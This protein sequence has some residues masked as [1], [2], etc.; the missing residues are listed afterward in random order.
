MGGLTI[1][2]TIILAIVEGLTEF[3]PVSSTG[4][5]YELL[6][7]EITEMSFGIF[8]LYSFNALRAPNRIVLLNVKRAVGLISFRANLVSIYP[9]LAEKSF[10]LIIASLS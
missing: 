5:M 10:P 2:Q 4:H 8:S 9:F 6:S 7:K 1:I 3:L